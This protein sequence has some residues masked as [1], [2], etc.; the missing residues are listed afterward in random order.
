MEHRYRYVLRDWEPTELDG[1]QFAEILG[2]L[3][4]HLDSGNLNLTKGFDECF[5]YIDLDTNKHIVVPR[6]DAKHLMFVLK[7]IYKF[8]S[9]RGSVHISPTYKPNHMDSKYLIEAVRWCFNEYLRLIW[10]GDKEELAKSVR[11][12]LRFDVPCI[13]VFDSNVIVQRTDISLEDELLLLLHHSGEDGYSRKQLLNYMKVSSQKMTS[14][15]SK[16]AGSMERKIILNSKQQYILTD[17]G[18]K[19]IREN[20]GDKLTL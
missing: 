1:G 13:G 17:L 18:N 11:E 20:L 12:L 14:I 8:R 4:Y 19:Y 15:L 10:N 3:L 16:M 5:K 7:T 9:Q 2:R 6:S